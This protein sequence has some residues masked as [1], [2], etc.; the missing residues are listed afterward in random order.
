MTSA[1]IED[2][3]TT[4]DAYGGNFNLGDI[5]TIGHFS[6]IGHQL[7]L[8][9]SKMRYCNIPVDEN[10]MEPG[11]YRGHFWHNLDAGFEQYVGRLNAGNRTDPVCEWAIGVSAVA[12]NKPLGT[13]TTGAEVMSDRTTLMKIASTPYSKNRYGWKLDAF[14]IGN[15]LL[16]CPQSIDEE[17]QHY[18]SSNGLKGVYRL[19]M[20]KN[21]ITQGFNGDD[22]KIDAS[23]SYH[24]VT[25]TRLTDGARSLKLLYAS[26]VD[27]VNRES[28]NVI[29]VRSHGKRMRP[30]DWLSRGPNWYIMSR[31]SGSRQLLIGVRT[32]DAR[33]EGI[34]RLPTDFMRAV[35]E[36]HSEW[37]AQVC[38]TFLYQVLTRM[39]DLLEGK[40]DGQLLTAS[41]S[42]KAPAVRFE[43]HDMGVPSQLFVSQKFWQQFAVHSARKAS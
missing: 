10:L 5:E 8:D 36:S 3:P 33:L 28:N 39:R 26:Q 22:D 19:E 27:C 1:P 35:S 13:V 4:P 23:S 21:A 16:I 38:F 41:Y 9:D 42:P 34:E 14:R 7:A 31:L 43:V 25:T 30:E 15:T 12:D 18:N 29:E 32:K 20:V 2:M 40:P 37:K 17:Q 24:R 6:R 11:S